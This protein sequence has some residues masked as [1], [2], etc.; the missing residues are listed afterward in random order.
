MKPTGV[1]GSTP[2]AGRQ[3]IWSLQPCVSCLRMRTF[4]RL[5]LRKTWPRCT[6][7]FWRNSRPRVSPQFQELCIPPRYGAYQWLDER[8]RMPVRY[9]Y[10]VMST[11]GIPGA[12]VTP[13]KMGAGSDTVFITSISA[14]AVDG[15]G[16]RM[17]T[18]LERDTSAVT[19]GEEASVTALF[20]FLRVVA[21]RPVQSGH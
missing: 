16:S 4:W 11:F 10:G 6:G 9:G 20:G 21:S 8:G 14:R 15:S 13:F 5:P 7:S 12:D 1:T 17:C 19:G 2:V 18:A 3:A